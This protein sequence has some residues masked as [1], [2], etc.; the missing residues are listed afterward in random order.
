M[1]R[2]H[3]AERNLYPEVLDI[4][5]EIKADHPDAIIGA[6]T[7][8][9]SNPLFMTFTLAPFFDFRCS[10]EDDQGKFKRQAFFRKL[11]STGGDTSQLS[12]IYDEAR[13]KYA[14]LK[15]AA[16]GMKMN[17]K[18]LEEPLV[19]PATY[20]D[21]AWIHVGDDLAFDIGGAAACGA[22]TIYLELDDARYGQSARHRYTSGEQ[23]PWSTTPESELRTR[24]EM[25]KAAEKKV[26]VKLNFLSTL[27]QAI[28]DILEAGE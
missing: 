21:R 18:D 11:D 17:V 16:D 23:A 7:D 15:N 12:W 4:L 20:D 9:R 10:W 28:K 6:V 2:H 14:E 25:A 13:Y 3:S 5:N 24:Y 8:G 1:E 26:D 27:P 19:Y 22:K